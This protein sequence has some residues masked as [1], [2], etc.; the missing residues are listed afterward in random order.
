MHD[1]GAHLKQLE[2]D[3][4]AS[5]TGD[6]HYALAQFLYFV[7]FNLWH[8]S[9]GRGYDSQGPIDFESEEQFAKFIESIPPGTDDQD[10]FSR[11]AEEYEKA[12][13]KYTADN[14]PL[15]KAATLRSLS[16][17]YD[18]VS[19]VDKRI[20]SLNRALEEFTKANEPA[21]MAMIYSDLSH[22]AA[23]IHGDSL[24]AFELLEKARHH[25]ELAGDKEGAAKSLSN[26]AELRNP[27]RA[28][29]VH[30]DI[31]IVI[32]N[33]VRAKELYLAVGHPL[34]AIGCMG[35]LANILGENNK[36]ELELKY[37]LEA[38]SLVE[39]HMGKEH[40][41]YN[42]EIVAGIYEQHGDTKNA[43]IYKKKAAEFAKFRVD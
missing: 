18:K 17:A 43:E 28:G 5:N 38:V 2:T 40:W 1:F 31:S 37:L 15:A 30:G 16:L 29:E 6:A 41:S 33:L 13:E 36:P 11:A 12:L 4:Q 39:K 35:A 24:K 22:V 8:S 3:A 10:L 9:I 19:E 27:M 32:Q 26:A 20:E 21:G 7:G 42:Y 14:N 34:D 25:Y 23:F